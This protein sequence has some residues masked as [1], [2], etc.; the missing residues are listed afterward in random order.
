[1]KFLPSFPVNMRLATVS[2]FPVNISGS[3]YLL[4]EVH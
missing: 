3:A 4:C 2:A 1:M